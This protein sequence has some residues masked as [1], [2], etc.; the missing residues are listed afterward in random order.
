MLI[1]REVE[2]LKGLRVAWVAR[3]AVKVAYV[4]VADI[5]RVGRRLIKCVEQRR[6][7]GVRDVP[8]VALLR[9]WCLSVSHTGRGSPAVKCLTYR[10]SR[11]TTLDHP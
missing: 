9:V 5:V 1:R 10:P 2:V 3:Q 4:Y 7:A 11:S 6:P 8:K